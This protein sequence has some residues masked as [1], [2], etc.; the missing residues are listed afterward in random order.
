MLSRFRRANSNTPNNNKNGTSRT[1][2]KDSN[3]PAA[4]GGVRRYNSSPSNN[5]NNNGS[6]SHHNNND[7]AAGAAAAECLHELRNKLDRLDELTEIIRLDI[8]DVVAKELQQQKLFPPLS[9]EERLPMKGR[10]T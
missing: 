5:N 3:S 10:V 2:G 1:F 8:F 9:T 7:D 4:S 6:S